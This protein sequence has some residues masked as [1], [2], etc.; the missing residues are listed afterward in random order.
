MWFERDRRGVHS[1]GLDARGQR[2]YFAPETLTALEGL[3]PS[4]LESLHDALAELEADVLV[5]Y[6]PEDESIDHDDE[7]AFRMVPPPT[8]IAFPPVTSDFATAFTEHVQGLDRRWRLDASAIAFE[9]VGTTLRP[10]W[11]RQ[12]A[13]RRAAW[14]LTARRR[15]GSRRVRRR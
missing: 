13:R 8:T 7:D 9:V 4:E 3:P 15:H 5:E 10:H 2:R 1:R 12:R 11:E 14:R 6:D